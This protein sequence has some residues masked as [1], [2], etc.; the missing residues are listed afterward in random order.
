MYRR[1][2]SQIGLEVFLPE[3]VFGEMKEVCRDYYPKESGGVLVGHIENDSTA[4]IERIIIPRWIYST[5][6][7]FRRKEAYI[8][9]QLKRIWKKSRG[10]TFY[11]GEWHCHPNMTSRYS[12]T[13][14]NAMVSIAS[15]P[16]VRMKNPIMM[17]I[18]YR[19]PVYSETVYV[20]ADDQLH[21]Y[22]KSE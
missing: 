1:Y 6:F 21:T 12:K 11:L 13:D 16:D 3:V 5:P 8:N 9:R 17:I 2:K 15:N 14:F 19:P 18:G 20:F 7:F 4:V 10:S 22:D